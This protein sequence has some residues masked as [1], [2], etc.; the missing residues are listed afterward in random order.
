[1]FWSV[2]EVPCSCS[3]VWADVAAA[4][5]AAAAAAAAG[6]AVAVVLGADRWP[7]LKDLRFLL[8]NQASVISWLGCS[9][10]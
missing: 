2:P 10:C 4:V 6:L 9:C 3:D 1:M 7:D 5:G 8:F